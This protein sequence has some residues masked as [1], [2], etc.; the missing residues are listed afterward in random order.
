MEL[1]CFELDMRGP[2]GSVAHVRLSRPDE[3]NTLVPAFWGE[4]RGLM[5]DLDARAQARAVVISSTGRHFSAGLDLSVISGDGMFRGSSD[6][7]R[8]RGR[9]LLYQGIRS[10]Q[11]TFTA[12]EQARMPVVAAVQGGCVGAAVALVAACDLRYATRDAFFLAAETDLGIVADVGQLQRLPRVLPDAVVREMVYRGTRLPADRAEGLGFVNAVHDDHES[13]LAA[14]DE[15]SDG[16]AAK[17][18]LALWGAKHA[19]RYAQDHPVADGL[20]QVA[21]WQAGMYHPGDAQES[22]RARQEDRSPT[23][24]PLEPLP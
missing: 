2:G 4:L 10:L 1:T 22:L 12:I 8:G 14:V 23:Y 15:V 13:L 24:D 16:L 3:R 21:L 6:T 7:E 20:D 19:I 5:L 18:P 9:E 11:A 17:S